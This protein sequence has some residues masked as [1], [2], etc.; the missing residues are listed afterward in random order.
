M[1][2]NLA[3]LRLA[4]LRGEAEQTV[5]GAV[6]RHLD[7]VD[8][9]CKRAGRPCTFVSTHARTHART[10]DRSIDQAASSHPEAR[11]EERRSHRMLGDPLELGEPSHVH[12]ILHKNLSS[13]GRTKAAG[14]RALDTPTSMEK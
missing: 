4:H 11:E 5:Q 1:G 8:V 3:K 13:L 7:A 2:C 6:R 12:G 9:L 14:T 10:I